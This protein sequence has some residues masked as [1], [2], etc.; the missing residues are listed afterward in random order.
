MFQ[1]IFDAEDAT[2]DQIQ[3][4]G[5][6]VDPQE[7]GEM[8]AFFLKFSDIFEA[9]GNPS[10]Q[11]L[12]KNINPGKMAIFFRESVNFDTTLVR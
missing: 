5:L 3:Q 7:R 6:N 11:I 8:S 9:V 10:D 2:L 4:T 1:N 12:Q